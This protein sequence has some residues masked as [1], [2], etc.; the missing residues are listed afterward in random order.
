MRNLSLP[1]CLVL[2][3]I[4]A[5]P[6]AAAQP[7]TV[8]FV[9]DMREEIAA[10]RFDPAQDK[11]GVR[12]GFAPLTWYQTL[13]ARDEDGDGRYEV[14]ILFP[15]RP[16][17]GQP[18]SYKFKVDSPKSPEGGWEEGTNRQVALTDGAQT[19]A[20]QFNEPPPPIRPTLTGTIRHHPGF[21][22]KFL[23]PRD[24]VVYLPPGYGTGGP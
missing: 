15:D 9:I 22:S 16:F 13:P 19:V 5:A 23:G 24:V 17:G 10:K 3:L 8:T 21:S 4:A 1:S 2:A 6:L 20:R 14:Q 7:S 12:S 18:V 11:V